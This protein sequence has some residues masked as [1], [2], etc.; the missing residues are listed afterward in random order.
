MSLKTA[1]LCVLCLLCVGCGADGSAIPTSPNSVTP[2]VLIGHLV[3]PIMS[4]VKFR[5]GAVSGITD[6][7]V[8]QEGGGRFVG[9]S[10]LGERHS[11]GGQ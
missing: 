5:S 4:A 9:S 8:R 2:A 11:E 7:A 10:R 1:A 6:E 3:G